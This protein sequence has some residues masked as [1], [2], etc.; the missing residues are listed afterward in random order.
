MQELVLSAIDRVQAWYR[1]ESQQAESTRG[2]KF[3]YRCKCGDSYHGYTPKSRC[4]ASLS[5][6]TMQL[7]ALCV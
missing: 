4:I 1:V 2:Q 5:T 7:R 6:S 3:S